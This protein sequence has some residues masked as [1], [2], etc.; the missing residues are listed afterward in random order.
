MNGKFHARTE[1]EPSPAWLTLPIIS[2]RR[3]RRSRTTWT[4]RLSWF[5][6]GCVVALILRG[7]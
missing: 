2:E 4:A 3:P 7:L 5:V 1:V 6:I